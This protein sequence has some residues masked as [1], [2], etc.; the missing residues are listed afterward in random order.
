MHI[1]LLEPYFTG[2]HAA[3]ANGLKKYSRH[4][5]TILSL[6]GAYWK[7]RMHGGAVTL[8]EQ[9]SRIDLKP[10][11]ILASD[12]LDLTTFLTLT[13]D[14]TNAVPAAVYFHEN[15]LSYPWS[16]QDR[17]IV[18]SR[19]K[20]YGFINYTSALAADRCFFNS[21]FHR[22]SFLKELPLFLTHFPDYNEL[23][24]LP[25]IE[26]KCRV[27]PLGLD[28]TRFDAIAPRNTVSEPP[29]ILW[30]HRWEYDKNPDDFF[31][32]IF[33][34]ADRGTAF[35]LVLLGEN[36]SRIPDVFEEARDRLG[37]RIIHYG[38]ADR[39]PDYAAWLKAAH[40]LPVTSIHDFFGASV[41]EAA[42]CSVLPLL[43]RR[44]SYP[45]IFP[46]DLFES[47]Y[48]DDLEQLGETVEHYCKTG[49][50]TRQ[51][52]EVS[53]HVARFDWQRII[54][55]YDEELALLIGGR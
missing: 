18:N 12:M 41:A 46:V 14:R 42:Y 33:T 30:N 7:W 25:R 53:A 2:S 8:A 17:D 29:I 20:H 23:R 28:L 38:Y 22:D 32:I 34:L 31:R 43:P 9:F 26:A 40:L 55:R 16:P 27:L 45:E 1:L 50:D 44:L 35:R 51:Q 52:K 49:V 5:V 24:S 21:A 37:S 36:F 15:Q 3:W 10:D 48:Y 19:D 11:C 54:T 47:L 4:R 13:R 39:F 6:K